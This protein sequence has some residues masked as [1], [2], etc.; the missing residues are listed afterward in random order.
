MSKQAPKSTLMLQLS[1]YILPTIIAFT[2]ILAV[3]VMF[4][5]IKKATNPTA[6]TAGDISATTTP[7]PT[8]VD[9]DK[10][11]ITVL[12]Q[13]TGT[14]AKSGDTVTVNYLGTL[15]KTGVKFDSSYDR[16]EPFS[17]TLGAGKVIQ[18]WEEGVLGMKVG[19]KRRLQIPAS[20]GYGAV[21]YSSIPGNST[22]MFD[23][24]L[25]KIGN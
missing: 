4:Y 21:D 25:V 19:E 5:A 17:F 24:E 7:M 8:V 3:I 23:V 10:F 9:A 1:E 15:K 6:S 20:K 2:V 18:G 13:G 11:E 22:L 14:A 16:K 12:T